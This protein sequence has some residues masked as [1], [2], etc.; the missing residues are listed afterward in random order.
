IEADGFCLCGA[1]ACGN[2]AKHPRY[3][4]WQADATAEEKVIGDWWSKKPQANIGIACGKVSNLT[5]LDVDV[6]PEVDGRDTLR[7]LELEH[8][9]LPETPIV[10]SGSGGLHYYFQYEPELRNAVKFAPGLDIRTEGGLVIGAGSR[11]KAGDYRW[12]AG[13]MLGD[14]GLVPAKMPQW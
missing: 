4:G 5:V 7:E 14:S 3:K 8:G 9:E 6:K 10:I 2:P 1:T 11:N 13:F 12:E